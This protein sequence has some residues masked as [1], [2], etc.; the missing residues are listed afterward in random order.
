MLNALNI[1]RPSYNNCH[2]ANSPRMELCF[3]LGF[4]GVL[5]L[6]AASKG[7]T[8]TGLL[9]LVPR[10]A[11]QGLPIICSGDT[12][13]P[14]L[15]YSAARHLCALHR[16]KYACPAQQVSVDS[17]P[18]L[19]RDALPTLDWLIPFTCESDTL[20][21]AICS[22][23]P[24]TWQ[25]D[26]QT[27]ACLSQETTQRYEVPPGLLAGFYRSTHIGSHYLICS[28]LRLA[29]TQYDA[30]PTIVPCLL[31]PARRQRWLQ[32]RGLAAALTNIRLCSEKF[33]LNDL[34]QIF[35]FL[36]STGSACTQISC[37]GSLSLIDNAK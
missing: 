21:A 30:L 24:G 8:T 4:C 26:L 34:Y 32:G 7:S 13:T 10:L 23:I 3:R 31:A 2:S 12:I 14:E 18:H 33:P 16:D 36:F 27:T 29:A 20:P 35:F 19:D 5:P 22:G 37:P 9:A 17:R 11:L 1:N 28:Q 25:G 15:H 6:E